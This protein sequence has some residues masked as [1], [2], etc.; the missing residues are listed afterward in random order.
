ML[1]LDVTG[2]AGV[3]DDAMAVALNVTVTQPSVDGY[4]TVYPCGQ[5]PPLASNLNFERGE[6]IP[7]LVITKV[8]AGG[9]C[10]PAPT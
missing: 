4:L 2:V 5:A 10:P 3:P 1:Q 7:N 9:G 8:G 6:T